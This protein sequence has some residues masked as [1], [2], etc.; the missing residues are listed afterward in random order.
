M[1]IGD[2]IIA[3]SYGFD[4]RS[5]AGG[6]IQEQEG[7]NFEDLLDRV[8]EYLH[9]EMYPVDAPWS[10]QRR[11]RPLPAGGRAVFPDTVPQDAAEAQA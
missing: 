3:G 8:K 11:L 6:E 5:P 4:I 2:P 1:G 7:T 10:S 9:R